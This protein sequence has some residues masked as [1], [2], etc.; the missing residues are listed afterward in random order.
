M[1]FHYI[2]NPPRIIRTP[3]HAILNNWI[4]IG[5]SSKLK[6]FLKLAV[7]PQSVNNFK[8]KWSIALR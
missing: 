2:L 3:V 7:C 4:L 6:K 1:G 5:E 8:L